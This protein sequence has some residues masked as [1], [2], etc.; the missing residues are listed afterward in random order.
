MTQQEGA[1]PAAEKKFTARS[2]DKSAK[3]KILVEKNPRKAG[4]VTHGIFELYKNDM[5]VGEF[6]AAGGHLI[7]VKADIERKHIEVISSSVDAAPVP[8]VEPTPAPVEAAEVHESAP[9]GV[10]CPGCSSA[11]VIKN[12][13]K[14]GQQLYKCKDCGKHFS[15]KHTAEVA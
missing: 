1:A 15:E 6:I 12:G 14:D 13:K 11:S 3:I 9:S 2:I 5:T 10:V 7:D 8:A 4:T